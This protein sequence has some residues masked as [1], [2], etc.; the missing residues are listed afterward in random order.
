[1]PR[2]HQGA[3]R[4]PQARS[5]WLLFPVSFVITNAIVVNVFFAIHMRVYGLPQG[6]VPSTFAYAIGY[7]I[8]GAVIS[9]VWPFLLSCLS[10]AV[11]RPPA[12]SRIIFLGAVAAVFAVIIGQ[13]VIPYCL[14]NLINF[15][16]LQVSSGLSAVVVLSCYYVKQFITVGRVGT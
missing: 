15:Y 12:R 6:Y 11:G 4:M 8:S 3:K 1:M 10:C 9:I 16:A 2:T 5:S 13:G 14:P 7:V